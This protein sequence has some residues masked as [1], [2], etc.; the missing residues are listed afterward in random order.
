[1]L[2][3]QGQFQY[4]VV[5]SLRQAIKLHQEIKLRSDNNIKQLQMD[6][7]QL[8]VAKYLIIGIATEKG[9]HHGAI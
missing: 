4:R 2:H 7:L 5:D 8:Q 3:I 1:M 9:G 6:L